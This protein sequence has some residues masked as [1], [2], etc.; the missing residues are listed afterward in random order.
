MIV[1]RLPDS[2]TTPVLALH[3]RASSL[4]TVSL[5]LIDP[6]AVSSSVVSSLPGLE[7]ATGEGEEEE[8][9]EEGV[10][11]GGDGTTIAARSDF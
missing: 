4:S 2:L 10:G 5:S 1:P 6:P 3:S 8:V 9:E 11:R 7:D